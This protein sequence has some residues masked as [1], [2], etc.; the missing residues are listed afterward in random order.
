MVLILSVAD[1]VLHVWFDFRITTEIGLL[2]SYSSTRFRLLCLRGRFVKT[3][4]LL[5][6]ACGSQN[7]VWLFQKLQ[8]LVVRPNV[9]NILGGVWFR[10]DFFLISEKSFLHFMYASGK[11]FLWHIERCAHFTHRRL[12]WCQAAIFRVRTIPKI[13]VF[14]VQFDEVEHL[15]VVP[16]AIRPIIVIVPGPHIVSMLPRLDCDTR[17]LKRKLCYTLQRRHFGWFALSTDLTYFRERVPRLTAATVFGKKYAERA[18]SL[19]NAIRIHKS[20][21]KTK[22]KRQMSKQKYPVVYWKRARTLNASIAFVSMRRSIWSER[23]V[24]VCSTIVSHTDV[25]DIWISN[26]YIFECIRVI[27]FS[28]WRIE[29]KTTLS[30]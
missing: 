12:S 29:V 11:L 25:S 15:L 2:R 17:E 1:N 5:F 24:D 10:F 23:A 8:I 26:F 9:D 16:F 18:S 3:L 19:N 27:I 7:L 4:A 14:F 13:A 6:L 28:T 22:L 21:W 30:P 20:D